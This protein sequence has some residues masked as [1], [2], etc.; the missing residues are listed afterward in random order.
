M[1]TW[2]RGVEQN[3]TEAVRLYKLAADQSNASAQA[4][5]GHMY[6]E[7]RGVERDN[8]EALRLYK[9]AVDQGDTTA[10]TD[11][12][13]RYEMGKGV[14]QDYREA[15]RLYQLAAG[16]GVA[17]AQYKTG[18][19]YEKILFEKDYVE[20]AKWYELAAKQNN[21][22]AQHRLGIF[23]KEGRVGVASDH[24]RAKELLEYAA[25]TYETEAHALDA[26]FELG[27]MYEKGMGVERNMVVAFKYYAVAAKREHPRAA[28]KIEGQ[29]FNI[30]EILE[31]AGD[32]IQFPK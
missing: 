7:G 18:H 27:E 8:K 3:D 19:I 20:A 10:Q 22:Q 14:E 4:S 6:F 1:Y 24:T 15:F 26:L 9:L 31:L 23:F 32:D 11:L 16:Q 13:Y 2:G 12:A 25:R 29:P 21:S 28:R 30:S 5:L 17:I